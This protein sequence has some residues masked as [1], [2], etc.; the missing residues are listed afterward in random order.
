MEKLKT[1][2]GK[3]SKKIEMFSNDSINSGLDALLKIL[4]NKKIVAI[5][6]NTHGTAE[7]Y[8]LRDIITR[9]LI[10]EKGFNTVV[11]ESPYDDIELLNQKLSSDSLDSLMNKHLFSIYQTLEM[12][13]FLEWYKAYGVNND[14]RFKGCDDSV[15]VIAEL[16][17]TQIEHIKDKKIHLLLSNLKKNIDLSSK[18]SLKKENKFDLDIYNDILKIEAYLSSTGNLTDSLKE[19]L[20][21]GK[22]SYKN[23]LNI[24]NGSPIQ[25]RDEIMAERI[26]YLAKNTNAKIIVWAHNAHIS[27]RII[28]NNEIGIMG[29]D[30]KL[31][32]G[33]DYYSIGLTSL[34][35]SYSYIEEKFINGDHKYNDKLKKA[36]IEPTQ[37]VTW[38]KVF[39]GIG[40]AFSIDLKILKTELK[41]DNVLGLTKLIG[42]GK[43][44]KED[45]YP[46]PILSNFDSLIFIEN[47]RATTPLF[48]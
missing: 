20:F 33:D 28:T 12:K 29:R 9:K 23:Y 46:L 41:T 11:L 35:G 3:S 18:N 39:A 21:N 45:I 17:D 2:I 25:S 10:Q 26:S 6:E 37:S 1:A 22:N 19:I 30:L 24:K 42:Y 4:E 44:T 14:I 36:E 48:N 31:E 38:E 5:G 34:G 32:Y 15:W 7:F 40:N 13:S 16:L 8:Q 47:T 27:N 43:E